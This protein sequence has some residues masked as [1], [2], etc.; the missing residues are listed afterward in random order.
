VPDEEP[1]WKE[2]S[3]AGL[4]RQIFIWIA[5]GG[6]TCVRVAMHLNSLGVPTAYQKDDRRVKEQGGLRKK[7]TAGIWRPSRVRAIVTN[8]VYKGENHYGRRPK[9]KRG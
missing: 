9:D 6:W 7:A 5:L 3:P 4:V 2:T 8:P 1:F